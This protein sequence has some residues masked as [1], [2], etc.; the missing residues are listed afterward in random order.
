MDNPAPPTNLGVAQMVEH[1]I[2]GR[3]VAGSSPV[4]QTNPWQPGQPWYEVLPCY[5]T[6]LEVSYV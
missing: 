4:T 6:Q 1:S 2:W 3:D 5:Y